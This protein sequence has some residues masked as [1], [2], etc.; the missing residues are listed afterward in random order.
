MIRRQNN[1]SCP[2]MLLRAAMVL[3]FI[4]APPTSAQEVPGS[5]AEFRFVAYSDTAAMQSLAPGSTLDSSTVTFSWDRPTGADDF[6]L[7]IGT[8]GAGSNEIR[9]SSVFNDTSIT[10]SGLPTN[11]QTVYVRLWTWINDWQYQDYTFQ[12]VDEDTGQNPNG[13][14]QSPVPESTLDS[15]AVTFIW[16]RPAGADDFDLIIG[17]TG[18]GSSDIR[19]ASVFNDTSMTVGGL[20][21]DGR[22]VYVRLWTWIDDWQYQDYTYQAVDD[23]AETPTEDDP[24]EVPDD[25]PPDNNPQGANYNFYF[26][27]LHEHTR[28]SDGDGTPEDMFDAGIRRGL[29]FMAASDHGYSISSSEA[30]DTASV[31]DDYYSPGTFTTF[32]SV[33][34]SDG[35]HLGVHDE[36]HSV[37]WFDDNYGHDYADIYDEIAA[38]GAVGVFHHPDRYGNQAFGGMSYSA[39]GDR[40]MTMMEIA[41]KGDIRDSHYFIWINALEKGWHLAPAAGDDNHSANWGR[42]DIRT[43]VLAEENSRTSLMEAMAERRV[44]ATDD[45]NLEIDFRINGNVMGSIIDNS[46]PATMTVFTRDGDG[47]S[48]STMELISGGWVIASHTGSGEWTMELDPSNPYYF[49]R[50]IQSD[51]DRA[52]TAPIWLE[53]GGAPGI[54]D[55]GPV[56]PTSLAGTYESSG[57]VNTTGANITAP[58]RANNGDYEVVSLGSSSTGG[59]EDAPID[60]SLMEAQG[61]GLVGVEGEFDRKVEVWIRENTGQGPI[62]ITGDGYDVA[63][64][65]L[66]LNQADYSFDINSLEVTLSDTHFSGRDHTTAPLNAPGGNHF[67]FAAMFFDDSVEIDDANGGDIIHAEHSFG[68]GDGFVAL[69][70]PAGANLPDYVEGRAHDSG[71]AQMVTVSFSPNGNSNNGGGPNPPQTTGQISWDQALAFDSNGDDHLY[72]AEF[73]N[74]MTFY[75]PD[76]STAEI[77]SL[78]DDL[79]SNNS[80]RVGEN[81]YAP[82][83][84]TNHDTDD[85]GSGDNTDDAPGQGDPIPPGMDLN[86]NG[87]ID[88]HEQ[89]GS[90]DAPLGWMNPIVDVEDLTFENAWRNP[91][92][93]MGVSITDAFEIAGN[94][95][96]QSRIREALGFIREKDP[97]SYKMIYAYCGR[98][99]QVSSGSGMWAFDEP[100]TYKLKESETAEF[101]W[102]VGILIHDPM[103]SAQTRD[104]AMYSEILG[105]NLERHANWI[106][107]RF[108]REIQMIDQAERWEALSGTHWR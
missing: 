54:P 46:G 1:F 94:S 8:T 61:F 33:E 48:I 10:V 64:N 96:F 56:S 102:L 9:S 42:D 4:I 68:D 66:T 50:I 87:V 84:Y 23:T 44:Y 72:Q 104:G 97:D 19:S 47:E 65:I 18:A 6:D 55:D 12:A 34:V 29:D 107:A 85:T 67:N 89:R 91:Q 11:G 27:H 28:F 38:H 69:L 63:W 7:I 71:G 40:V 77:F 35:D 21:T 106:A 53:A 93:F 62:T 78:F 82:V 95:T 20:P 60:R 31:A 105:D 17:T 43:V 22:T 70:Y 92:G 51:G 101:Y 15:S 37:L 5:E 83:A 13:P 90:Y 16:N 75:S 45:S 99:E 79:D 100:P 58:S 25:S 59:G 80:G 57:G 3:T 32:A 49:I 36:D 26:G 98:F 52:V 73:E 39:T 24:P 2:L 14:M 86:A 108:F 103:H 88:I 30:F 81:E 74:I 76:I 41:N